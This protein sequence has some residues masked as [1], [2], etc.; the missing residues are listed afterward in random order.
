MIICSNLRCDTV[1]R[2][3]AVDPQPIIE[4]LFLNLSNGNPLYLSGKQAG[5]KPCL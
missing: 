4:A 3:L 2:L 5:L 1:G